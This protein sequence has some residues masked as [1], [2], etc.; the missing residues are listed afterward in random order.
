M[1]PQ[2]ALLT[3]PPARSFVQFLLHRGQTEVWEM[4][5]AKSLVQIGGKAEGKHEVGSPCL[6]W[7]CVGT[8]PYNTSSTIFSDLLLLSDHF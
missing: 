5:G 8:L 3:A 4:K 1:F 2:L 6:P 7:C